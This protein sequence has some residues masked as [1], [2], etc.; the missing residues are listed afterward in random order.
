MS[1][2]RVAHEPAGAGVARRRLVTELTSRG[3]PAPLLDDVALVVS[4]LVGNAVRH[5]SPLPDG[6]GVLVTWELTGPVLHLEVCDGGSG[7]AD[8]D[9]VQHAPLSAEGGRGLAIVATVATR[10]GTLE[11]DGVT[12]VQAELPVSA[13]GEQ[14]ATA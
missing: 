9:A 3:L 5:G 4:E 13:H 11:R 12:C 2:L 7:P 10:W 8:V 1:S 14:Y 6:G